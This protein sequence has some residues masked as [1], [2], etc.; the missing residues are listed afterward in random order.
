MAKNKKSNQKRTTLTGRIFKWMCATVGASLF[1][2]SALNIG[3]SYSFLNDALVSELS[4][5]SNL[6]SNIVSNQITTLKNAVTQFTLDA[7]FVDIWNTEA[8]TA[9]CGAIKQEYPMY[10]NVDVITKLKESVNSDSRV[11]YTTN[12]NFLN[13]L[14][15]DMMVITDPY[16]VEHK[17]TMAIDIYA[18]IHTMDITKSV[19][20]VLYLQVDVNYFSDVVSKIHIGQTGYAFVVDKNGYVIGSNNPENVKNQ[21]NYV[22]SQA[23]TPLADAI[24]AATRGGE[25]FANVTIDGAGKYIYYSPVPDSN[26]WACIMVSN[27]AEHTSAIYTSVLVGAIAAI[28]CFAITVI[29]ILKVVKTIIKPVELCSKQIVNLSEGNLHQRPLDFGNGVS[30][31]I[32]ELSESTNQIATNMNAV[33]GDLINML[34]AFGKGDLTYKPADVYIGDFSP[35]YD[36]YERIHLSLNNT[37][38]NINKAGKQVSDGASQVASA[39]NNLSE[40]ATKQAASIEELSASI[41]E[42]TDKVNRNAARANNAAENSETATRLVE[43]GNKQMKVLLEAMTEI[44]D[45]S[46][47][48]AKII[49]TIDDISFQ[50]NILALNAAVEAARAGEAGKGF[51]VVADEVRNLAGKV[52][53]AASDT[54]VL[55]NNSIDAV[56]NGTK[57]ADETAKTLD[58]IVQTTTETTTLVTDISTASIEQAE[59]LQ[60]VTVGVDQISSVVQTNSATSEECAAS[61]E[62]LSSQASIL[63]SMVAKFKL[64]KELL[65]SPDRF[66]ALEALERGET[67][68]LMKPTTT[69]EATEETEAEVN[70]E[71]L[72]PADAKKAA[73]EKAKKEKA[74]KKAKEK[75]EKKAKEKAEKELAKA[76][77]AEE[78]AKQKAEKEAQATAEAVT[79]TVEEVA[80]AV[81]ETTEVKAE[82]KPAEATENTEVKEEKAEAPVEK[83]PAKKS[84]FNKF[85]S[86]FNEDP[87]DKY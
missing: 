81:A 72:S 39:A 48:I 16:Y 24:T 62:E 2:V 44:N 12:Q 76:K 67:I 6:S 42:I 31:E 5:V 11:D 65:D 45:T 35:L 56:D 22:T 32:A 83:K 18:P 38:D 68:C 59:S 1:I 49:R 23:G 28:V 54:T 3:M 70:E 53:Q 47:E 74:E 78:K 61:A 73:K 37:M 50:T 55:I 52:A 84:R 17:E 14:E 34:G 21:L 30:K 64:D 41:A 66:T 40:G 87:N 71:A 58:K 82:E 43:S 51:A 46:T 19:L 33:I 15:N 13:A 77:A 29:I 8:A 63:D 86:D 79:E 57:I 26:G 69:E 36:A 4:E 20:G 27:P 85:N 10:I 9:K 80:E 7:S 60:Q 75:A 25:G